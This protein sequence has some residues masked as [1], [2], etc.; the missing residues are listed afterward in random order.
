[1]VCF[2]L[3]LAP[4]RAYRLLQ[5][6]RPTMTCREI[7]DREDVIATFSLV[8]S[9]AIIAICLAA[10]MLLYY[11]TLRH[12]ANV[13]L[14]WYIRSHGDFWIVFLGVAWCLSPI[15]LFLLV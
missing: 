10:V 15:L 12:P 7:S 8:K 14:F 6:R 1:M 4:P 5:T 13:P 2:Y 9:S 3:M 11:A